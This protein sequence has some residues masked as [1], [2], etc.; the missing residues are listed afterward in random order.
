MASKCG[1]G[2]CMGGAALSDRRVLPLV[3]SWE[4]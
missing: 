1:R 3:A 4:R 2:P